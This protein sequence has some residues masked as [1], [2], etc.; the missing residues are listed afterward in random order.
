MKW[1]EK[2]CEKAKDMKKW[3]QRDATKRRNME[4]PFGSSIAA[5]SSNSLVWLL[6]YSMAAFSVK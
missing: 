3:K 5:C 6:G 1:N 4:V 2:R